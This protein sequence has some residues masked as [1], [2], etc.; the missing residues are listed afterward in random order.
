MSHETNHNPSGQQVSRHPHSVLSPVEKL[1]FLSTAVS[2]KKLT[3][4]QLAALVVIVD[5]ANG[6]T[7][8]CW[9][10][11]STVAKRAGISDL[12]NAGRAV[13]ALVDKGLIIRAKRGTR[14]TATVYRLNASLVDKAEKPST[15]LGQHRP[16][17]W[18]ST[19]PTLGS[20]VTHQ[21]VKESIYLISQSESDRP[22]DEIITS[23]IQRA[24]QFEDFW[25]AYGKRQQVSDCEELLEQYLAEGH[26]LKAIVDGAKRAR[27]HAEQTN[28]QKRF[29]PLKWLQRKK[30]L[31]D[32]TVPQEAQPRRRRKML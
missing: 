4:D 1:Q 24:E 3:R 20:A 19:D 27:L 17:P 14:T 10:S 29:S 23:S 16:N 15:T 5:M 26:Q 6:K 30:W 28:A 18:V 7:G 25:H 22:T 8:D 32:W 31:D 9:P 12:N 13:R 21:S 2:T 11:Y